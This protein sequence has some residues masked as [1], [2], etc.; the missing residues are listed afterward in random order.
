MRGNDKDGGARAAL[1][2]KKEKKLETKAGLE[3][4]IYKHV[5]CLMEV[6]RLQTTLL[7]S[8]SSMVEFQKQQKR[9]H[10]QDARATKKLSSLAE[11]VKGERK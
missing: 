10:G 8:L 7:A 5:G 4:E 6:N 9:N 11:K 1:L 2:L 3:K